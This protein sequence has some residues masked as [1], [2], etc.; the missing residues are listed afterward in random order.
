MKTYSANDAPTEILDLAAKLIPEFLAGNHPTLAILRNQYE[1]ARIKQVELSG[2]GFFIYYEIPENLP[3]VSP[4]NFEGG[5]A[6]IRLNN[7]VNPAAC[8][9][10]IRNGRIDWFESYTYD[11]DWT[12]DAKIVSISSVIP[13]TPPEQ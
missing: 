9:L 6:D 8:H 1:Q 5:N 12:E 10:F 2:V 11:G 7:L 4:S 3:L 13:L